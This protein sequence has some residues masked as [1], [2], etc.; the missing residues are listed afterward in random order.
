LREL[1]HSGR[2]VYWLIDDPWTKKRSPEFETLQQSFRLEALA[3]GVAKNGIKQPFFGRI[4][5]LA[6]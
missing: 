3:A 2:S 6:E 4:Y 1:L 5:E